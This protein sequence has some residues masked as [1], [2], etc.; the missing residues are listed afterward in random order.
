MTNL[1]RDH[2]KVTYAFIHLIIASLALLHHLMISRRSLKSIP[3][4]DYLWLMF[5]TDIYLLIE[6]D[7]SQYTL[8]DPRQLVHHLWM[9]SMIISRNNPSFMC[10]LHHYKRKI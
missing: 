10:L 9:L 8:L 5:L 7:N 4:G 6:E 2:L 1:S 3:I